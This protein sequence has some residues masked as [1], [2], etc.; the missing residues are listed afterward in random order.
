MGV[1]VGVVDVSSAASRCTLMRRD[2]RLGNPGKYRQVGQNRIDDG[3]IWRWMILE[4]KVRLV[5]F[6]LV[7]HL[8]AQPKIVSQYGTRVRRSHLGDDPPCKIETAASDCP[9]IQRK[10][11][12]SLAALAGFGWL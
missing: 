12:G 2:T 5:N 10:W 1:G 3:F 7:F 6:Y 4:K 8:N 11:P 9:K